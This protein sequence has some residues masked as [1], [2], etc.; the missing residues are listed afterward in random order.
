MKIRDIRKFGVAIVI[1]QRF[2]EEGQNA[3]KRKKTI[4]EKSRS[5]RRNRV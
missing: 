2:F 1:L 4:S 5:N 3:G